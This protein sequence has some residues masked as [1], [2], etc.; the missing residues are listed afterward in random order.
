MRSI[1]LAAA[2]ADQSGSMLCKKTRI[3]VDGG[4]IS[5]PCEPVSQQRPNHILPVAA[6]HVVVAIG[7]D[8]FNNV[9]R[10]PQMH[11][12]GAGRRATAP[13]TSIPQYLRIPMITQGKPIKRRWQM[14]TTRAP[15]ERDKLGLASNVLLLAGKQPSTRSGL[16]IIEFPQAVDK[17][18]PSARARC[19]CRY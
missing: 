17:A 9:L 10:K 14:T 19:R 6:H 18:P 16:L 8:C 4:Q 5:Q 2:G 13:G 3:S 7:I 15:I 11:S 12:L 1:P